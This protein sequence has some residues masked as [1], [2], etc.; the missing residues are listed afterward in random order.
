MPHFTIFSVRMQVNQKS[1]HSSGNLHDL[2]CVCK[3]P[4]SFFSPEFA[5]TLKM[6]NFCSRFRRDHMHRKLASGETN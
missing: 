4:P 2:E 1:S 6:F 5:S 3:I